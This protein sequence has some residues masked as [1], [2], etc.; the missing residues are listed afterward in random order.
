MKRLSVVEKILFICSILLLFFLLLCCFFPEFFCSL[1][2]YQ[3]DLNKTFC[4]CS[5]QHIL[6]CDWLG[7][8]VFA[9]LVYGA[10]YSL[11]IGFLSSLCSI[12]VPLLICSILFFA[13][14]AI[15][16]CYLFILDIF[17]AFPP[18]LFA[19]LVT[20]V[21]DGGFYSTIF[22]LILSGWAGN[23]RIL[24]AYL[25]GLKT[26][27]FVLAAVALGVSD[28]NIFWRHVLPNLYSPLLVL[29]SLKIGT[30][31]LA[32]STLSFLGLGGNDLLSWGTM[33]NGGKDYLSSFFILSF[34]PAFMIA[35]SVFAFQI[36]GESLE[37]INS[38]VQYGYR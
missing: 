35:I 37:K 26:K 24:R 21:T 22:A 13:P 18:L 10:G 11:K 20:A 3:Q 2:P 33:V 6:G 17:L 9:R 31:I 23:G 5:A 12:V 30:F 8:D 29:F 27:E 4:S 25:L 15:D 32:E 19:I 14:L 28:K 38:G 16:H 36:I 34:A 1:N 7:R